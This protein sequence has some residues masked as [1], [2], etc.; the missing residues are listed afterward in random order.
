[1]P[2]APVGAGPAV[3]GATVEAFVG[4]VEAVEVDAGTPLVGTGV[5][6]GDGEKMLS[7]CVGEG[8]AASFVLLVGATVDA[9]GPYVAVG[10][11][12][13]CDEQEIS[14]NA[15]KHSIATGA[16]F[17]LTTTTPLTY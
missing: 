9:V 14:E 8:V 15:T 3:E 1:M 2:T 6:D 4:A 16:I 13:R 10:D 11:I 17:P 5:A 7:A 12:K